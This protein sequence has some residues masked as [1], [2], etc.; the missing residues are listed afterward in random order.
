MFMEKWKFPNSQNNFKNKIKDTTLSN[1]KLYYKDIVI[2][3]DT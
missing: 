1:F 3:I 2:K